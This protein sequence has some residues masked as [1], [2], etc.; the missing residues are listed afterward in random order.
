MKKIRRALLVWI[1]MILAMV[2]VQTTEGATKR[3]TLSRAQKAEISARERAGRVYETRQ[4]NLENQ[5]RRGREIQAGTYK[6]PN[7][8]VGLEALGNAVAPTAPVAMATVVNGYS[9]ETVMLAVASTAGVTLLL[10]VYY[11]RFTEGGGKYNLAPE[12]LLALDGANYVPKL[13]DIGYII[14]EAVT[15]DEKAMETPVDAKLEPKPTRNKKSAAPRKTA[16]RPRKP[17]AVPDV[18][19]AVETPLVVTA[20]AVLPQVVM[21]V[22]VIP[23]P[24]SEGPAGAPESEVLEAASEVVVTEDPNFFPNEEIVP[25]ETLAQHMP[26]IIPVDTDGALDC[27]ASESKTESPSVTH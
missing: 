22:A 14:P 7:D 24:Q 27:F 20:P 16:V 19:P 26:T 18:D 15:K 21:A 9:N 12:E 2:V 23:D 5:A 6:D 17:R 4:I 25:W 3:R 8:K 13:F 10:T 1:V 11:R